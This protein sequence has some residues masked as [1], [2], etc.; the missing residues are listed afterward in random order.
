MNPTLK[1]RLI[2]LAIAAAVLAGGAYAWSRVVI[3]FQTF[4]AKY[5]T[6]FRVKDCVYPNP[7]VTACFLG[8][9]RWI[10]PQLFA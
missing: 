4:I 3:Q 7:F 10:I 6:I 1:N 9:G 2:L 5:G 8:S